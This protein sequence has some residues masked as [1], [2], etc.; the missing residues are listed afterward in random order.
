MQDQ[1]V[2]AGWGALCTRAGA[3]AAPL[4]LC[5]SLALSVKLFF[6]VSFPLKLPR[7]DFFFL[8]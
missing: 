1:T 5:M 3:P 4:E 6:P 2:P 8:Q 7:F